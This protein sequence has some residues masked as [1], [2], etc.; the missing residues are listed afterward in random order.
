MSETPNPQSPS[1]AD[2]SE[3]GA[4]TLDLP[5]NVGLEQ[6][7]LSALMN[8]EDAY[9]SVSDTI[10]GDDFFHDRH[11]HIFNSIAY[12]AAANE[13]YD[14]VTVHDTLAKQDL[15]KAVGGEEYLA[16]IQQSPA[17]LFNLRAYAER[18]RELSIYRQLIGAA[19]RIL[20]LAHHPKK[21]SAADVLGEAEA[22][23]FAIG[24]KMGRQQGHQGLKEGFLV[25]EN[26]SKS[27]HERKLMDNGGLLG[28]DTSFE[29]LNNKTQGLQKGNL[30][31]LAARP[32]MGKTAFALN[33]AQSVLNQNLPVVVFSMEMS[34]EDIVMRMLSAWG[35]IHQGHLR[36][37]QMNDAEW[38]MF[39][40]GA[41]HIIHSKLYIDDRNNLP[42][43]E[44]RSVCRKV[45]KN[46]DTGLGLV[47]VDYLQ[48]MKVPGMENNRLNEI[49]EI[50]RSLKA[51]AREMNCPVLALSQLS[52]NPELR[53]QKRPIM[54]DLR[55]SGSLEQDA[56]IVMFIYRDEYYNK[57]SQRKGIA[58][59]IVGKNRNGPIGTVYLKYTGEYLLFENPS[60]DIH[61]DEE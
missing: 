16:K 61:I 59:I 43:S 47:V 50:S 52:R 7:L 46:Y 31:I 27:L 57:D 39:N 49:G 24:E 51:L 4:P 8:V 11:R 42:P 2:R 35:R 13:P 21:Q 10:S 23:I 40:N 19:G 25:M 58:E 54:S 34:A 60:H 32:S 26:V 45:A 56:D 12:L 15:L 41:T 28:L 18:V 1:V 3:R 17:S 9:D 29:E 48:L 6:G 44:V 33:V 20:K 36:S 37:G 5:H 30:L 38:A 14:I 55:E 53:P 22:E